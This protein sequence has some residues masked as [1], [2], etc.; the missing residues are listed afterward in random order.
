L[1]DIYSYFVYYLGE[2]IIQPASVVTTQELKANHCNFIHTS[3]ELQHCY[4]ETI[5]Q[6]TER[7]QAF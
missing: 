7:S 5:K 1:I 2:P 3:C 4:H 6:D